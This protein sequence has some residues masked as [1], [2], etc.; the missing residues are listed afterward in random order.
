MWMRLLDQLLRQAIRTGTL[1]VH[2]PVGAP[3]RYGDGQGRPVTVRL[4]DESLVRRILLNPDL[5]IGE[6]Y[7]EGSF[8]I[9][10]DDLHGFLALAVRNSQNAWR[11]PLHR[12]LWKLRYLSRVARQYNPAGRAR[13]RVAHHYDLSGELYDLFLD[14]DKQYSCAYFRSPDDTLEQAQAQKK[15]HIAGKLRIEPGM[16]VLDIGCGWGGLALTLARDYGARVLGVTLSEEQHE[17]ANE[18]ARAA[19]LGNRAQFRLMDY[20]E[21]EGTFDRVVS[22]GMF[23]HVGAP[24]YREYFR[25]VREKLTEDGIALIHTIGRSTPPGANSPWIEKYIFPGGYIPALSEIM[26]AVEKEDFISQDIEVWRL[27]YAQTLRHWHDRFV[28]NEERVREIYDDRFCR[29]WRYYLVACEQTF[30][31]NRQVVFQLQLARKL[32]AVPIT[33]DYLYDGSEVRRDDMAAE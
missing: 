19:G 16:R 2:P 22:V 14:S 3:L 31:C 20:R 9:D 29:M 24:H 28:A 11:H 33:R 6:G 17:V 21:V 30:R 13:R 32:Q 18:R 25:T 1:V 4:H 7:M 27:H 23:E 8:T 26:T 12:F 10:D 5:G 15:A